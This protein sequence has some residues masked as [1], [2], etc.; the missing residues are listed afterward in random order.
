MTIDPERLEKCLAALIES[1]DE[2]SNAVSAAAENRTG[3]DSDCYSAL[4]L[5]GQ[6]TAAA[7]EQLRHLF[8]KTEGSTEPSE[9]L[10][11]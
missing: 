7:R 1:L 8:R 4:G 5:A 6:T 9:L 11:E 3:Y 2:L 10:P